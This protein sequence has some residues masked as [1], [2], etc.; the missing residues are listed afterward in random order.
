MSE[1]RQDLLNWIN[2]LLGLQLSKI[3]E[4]GKGY[5]LCQVCESH[6]YQLIV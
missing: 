2:N 5:A 6:S 1:S 3:E 4:L